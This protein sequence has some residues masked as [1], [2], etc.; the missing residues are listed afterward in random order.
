M[1][2]NPSASIGRFHSISFPSEWGVDEDASG[3][4]LGTAIKFPFN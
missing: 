3:V 1:T 2:E 4:T